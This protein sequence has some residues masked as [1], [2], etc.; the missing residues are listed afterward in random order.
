MVRNFT[1]VQKEPSNPKVQITF[2]SDFA[3]GRNSDAASQGSPLFS[4]LIF[5]K[6]TKKFLRIQLISLIFRLI[7]FSKFKHTFFSFF[8]TD[9]FCRKS[10]RLL[11]IP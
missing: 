1:Q 8:F 3:V 7:F 4:I 10:I 2:N 6:H 5:R 11:H 9:F